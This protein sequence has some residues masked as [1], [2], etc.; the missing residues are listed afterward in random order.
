MHS[1]YIFFCINI[2]FALPWAFLGRATRHN[3]GL[4]V[5]EA[6]GDDGV[7]LLKFGRESSFLC[8]S[9]F[10][11]HTGGDQPSGRGNETERV[12]RFRVARVGGLVELRED[13]D[14]W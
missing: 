9:G 11:S 3:D 13:G 10:I 8:M 1:I 7:Q 14:G 2:L 4:D 12:E 6:V 5:L